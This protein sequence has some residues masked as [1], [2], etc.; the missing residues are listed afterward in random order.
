MDAYDI[1]TWGGEILSIMLPFMVK[2]ENFSDHPRIM[3]S[4]DCIKNY[5]TTGSR[6][7]RKTVHKMIS[8]NM[9]NCDDTPVQHLNCHTKQCNGGN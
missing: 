4:S 7:L 6:K 8:R 1:P 5:I 3:H 9:K 2:A